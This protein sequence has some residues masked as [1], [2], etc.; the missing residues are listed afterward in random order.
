MSK[1][2]R[3]IDVV[4]VG[5]EYGKL[6]VIAIGKSDRHGLTIVCE[7]R[8]GHAKCKKI[9]VKRASNVVKG[10]TKTCGAKATLEDHG[11]ASKSSPHH[12][13]YRSWEH[14]IDRC[15]NED[16]PHYRHY[17]GRGISVCQRWRDSFLAFLADMGDRPDGMTLERIETD[18]NYDP[19]NCKWATYQEQNRNKTNGTKV[20]FRGKTKSVTEWSETTGIP[21]HVI[22]A[23]LNLAWSIDR[24][25]TSPVRKRRWFRKP[26]ENTT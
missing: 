13:A 3:L 14:M 2:S 12:N 17:G 23:R 11:C 26:S 1:R 4:Q 18:L 19:R 9:T 22:F 25:L 7:C 10:L 20:E 16:H 15:Y 24:A 6:I 21:R 5:D 8:C